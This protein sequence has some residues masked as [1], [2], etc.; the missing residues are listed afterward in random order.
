VTEPSGFRA[1]PERPTVLVALVCVSALLVL[2]VAGSLLSPDP[3]RFDLFRSCL[4]SKKGLSLGDVSERDAIA[5]SGKDAT[6]TTIE[7][8]PVTIVNASDT[9]SAIRIE[10]DY[11]AVGAD[12]PAGRL[13]RRGPLVYVWAGPASPTQRQ[14][15]YD[16]ADELEGLSSW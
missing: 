11:E 10:R 15:V 16:C 13:E 6:Q 9:G 4:G 3:T 2:G 1:L 14:T 12:A 7:G 5:R 8:N